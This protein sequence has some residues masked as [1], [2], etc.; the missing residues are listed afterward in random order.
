MPAAV[1][2]GGGATGRR[3]D[4]ALIVEPGDYAADAAVWATYA[5]RGVLVSAAPVAVGGSG[6]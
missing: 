1:A 6:S 3:G 2:V 5:A 4:Y